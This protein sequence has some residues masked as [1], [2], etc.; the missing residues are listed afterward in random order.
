[1]PALWGGVYAEMKSDLKLDWCS[2][3]AAKYAVEHWHYSRAVPVGKTV[4]VGVWENCQFIGAVVFSCGSAG[5]GSIGKSLSLTP[6]EVAELARVALSGHVSYVTRIISISIS[7]LKKSQPG[8]RLLVSYA[9][10][11]QGHI[12]SVY[13]GGNWIFSGRSSPDCAYV[14][15]NG[16]RWHSRSVSESGYKTRL[17]KKTKAPSPVGMSK[18]ELLPK[19]RYLYPLDP[20]MRAQIAPLAKPYPKRG[21][22]ETDNAPQTNAETEGASPIVPL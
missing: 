22:G 18:V 10:P 16:K 7:M 15:G 9:D 1:M 17:G 12:G 2:Y 13:Q 6:M 8:L 19:Y 20:A 21:T 5:V 3:Q 4:R 14:D 11:G